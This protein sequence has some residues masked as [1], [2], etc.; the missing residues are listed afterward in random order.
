VIIKELVR[1]GII[2]EDID[3]VEVEAMF[4]SENRT[5]SAFPLR[6]TAQDRAASLNTEG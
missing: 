6:T 1:R 5:S 4:A 2:S 3:P